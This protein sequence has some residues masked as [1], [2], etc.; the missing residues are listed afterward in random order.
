M[1]NCPENEVRAIATALSVLSL[2]LLAGCGDSANLPEQA[3]IGPDPPIPEP[4]FAG[5]LDHPRWLAVLP[6]GDVLVAESN[7]PNAL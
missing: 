5:G 7:A 2:T 6:N 4:T 3:S 1:G